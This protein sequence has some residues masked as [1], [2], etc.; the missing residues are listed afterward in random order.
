MPE[1]SSFIGQIDN[2]KEYD[3]IAAAIELSRRGLLY[4]R[5]YYYNE[6][7]EVKG[8]VV[9]INLKLSDA[10]ADRWKKKLK[11]L[12]D[13]SSYKSLY[14]EIKKMRYSYRNLFQFSWFSFRMKSIKSLVDVY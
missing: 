7:I 1:Y 6:N 4:L 10:L 12:G 2:E 13:F 14:D 9:G 8:M 3:S 11:Y 5:K